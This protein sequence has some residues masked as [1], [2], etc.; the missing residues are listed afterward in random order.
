ME[1]TLFT[2]KILPSVSFEIPRRIH[3]KAESFLHLSLLD[4]NDFYF[5]N[6]KHFAIGNTSINKQLTL[7][8]KNP[9]SKMVHERLYI[10]VCIFLNQE[11]KDY[12]DNLQTKLE[13][14]FDEL[15]YSE[16]LSCV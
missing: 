10:S 5:V 9:T 7:L 11:R 14:L 4:T 3:L 1:L 15:A 8:R 13:D 2:S 12:D 6:T 16:S